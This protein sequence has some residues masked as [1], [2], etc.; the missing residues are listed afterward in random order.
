M[1]TPKRQ[2]KFENLDLGI[3]KEYAQKFVENNKTFGYVVHEILKTEDELSKNLMEWEEKDIVEFLKSFHSISTISLSGRMNVLRNLGNFISDEMCIKRRSFTIGK[4]S[5][6]ECIDMDKL[7]SRTISFEQYK[8]IK[9]QLSITENGK[10]YNI[11]DKLIFELAW[12]GLSHEEIKY[13]KEKDID[14]VESDYGWDIAMIHFDDGKII[15][16]EEPEV[17]EDIKKVMKEY[18][19]IVYSKDGL[20][21][22]MDYKDSEY[23]LKPIQVG[24]GKLKTYISNPGLTIQNIFNSNS[25]PILCDGIDMCNLSLEDIRRSKL[26]YLL[27]EQNSQYID[28]NLITVLFDMKVESGL[29]WLKKVA[30]IKYNAKK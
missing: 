28:M 30:K 20:Q 1:T 29:Y 21:K 6:L 14:F 7:L 16:I 27:S 25:N 19:Y 13:I 2:P 24:R 12:Q 9:N 3:N 8:H 18:K 17:V 22:T 15:K 4:N 26:I 10:D 11:R 5:F 23:L